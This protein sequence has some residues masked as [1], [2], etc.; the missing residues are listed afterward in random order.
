MDDESW[1]LTDDIFNKNKNLFNPKNPW[2]SNTAIAQLLFKN[3]YIFQKNFPQYLVET[4]YVSEFFIFLNS[5]GVNS[6]FF[7]LRLNSFLLNTVDLIDK[8]LI[9]L[10]PGIFALNRTIVLRKISEG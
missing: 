3:K 5:G 10:F 8:V 6:N 9:F 1:S 7:S 2:I 4:N